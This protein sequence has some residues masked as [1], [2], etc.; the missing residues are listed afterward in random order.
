MTLDAGFDVS[1]LA[2][3]DALDQVWKVLPEARLVGGVVRDL[4]AGRPSM[5]IDL[6]TPLPPDAVIQRLSQAGLRT[7]PTGLA[8]GTVTALVLDHPI[9]IT[10]LRRDEAT[11]GRHAVVAWTT[12]WQEDA[13][14]RDFTINAM[15][16]TRDGVLHDYFGGA[17]DLAAGHVRFVGLASKRIEEDALRMLRFFRFQARY[18]TG[19]PDREAVDAIAAALPALDGLSAERVWSEL[20]R[21]LLAPDPAA[22]LLLMQSLG[23]LDRLLPGGSAADRLVWR[24]AHLAIP[25]EVA[26]DPVLR[27][28]ALLRGPA[29][30]VADALRLSR[31]ESEQL[32]ALL[33]DRPAPVA[34]LDDAALRRMLADEP[35]SL[36]LG[37]GWLRHDGENPAGWCAVC[38]RLRAMAPPVFP[39]AGR[40]LL[41]IGLPAGPALGRLLAATRGWWLQGGCS[42][43]HAACL[44]HCLDRAR[45]AGVLAN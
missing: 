43:D 14:R 24:L 4:L 38:G 42:A 15:S 27:L 41:A 1:R 2:G 19:A 28:A 17:A 36:L 3:K 16:L 32:A 23:V 26:G 40:D 10:T 22:T 29:G 30:P 18:G 7:I 11:D 39:L 9:E 34:G 6:A 5:D 13:A 37:R 12:D 44:A 20:R 8:H 31:A 45:E 21:I 33:A 25:E 35:A